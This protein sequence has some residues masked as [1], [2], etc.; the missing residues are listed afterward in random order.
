METGARGK[1]G[2]ADARG[3]EMSKDKMYPIYEI[4]GD[5]HSLGRTEDMGEGWYYGLPDGR[6]WNGCSATRMFRE[7]LTP[8]KIREVETE[9]CKDWLKSQIEKGKDPQDMV[10]TMKLARHEHW[11]LTW[12]QHWTWRDGRSDK[13]ILDSFQEYVFR[14]EDLNRERPQNEQICL[15]GAEDRWRWKGSKTGGNGPEDDTDPPC[16]C[17]HCKEQGVVRIGH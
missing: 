16:N 2:V 12:F 7:E 11:C 17:K 3:G 4:R 9:C 8:E 14:I 13:E 1:S 15:M 10:V 6:I 5:W